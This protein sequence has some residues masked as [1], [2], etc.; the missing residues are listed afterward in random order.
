MKSGIK[1]LYG[2]GLN[3]AD[4]T[5]NKLIAGKRIWCKFYTR[6]RNMLARCYDL[7]YQEN[8]PTYIGCS[9]AKEWHSFM[10]FRGWME[11]QDW[12]GNH[13]DKDLL[14]NGNKVYSPETCVFI[15]HELNNFTLDSS[16]SR[17]LWPV[18]VS[19]HNS[20]GMF[21]AYC[22]NPFSKIKDHI[23]YFSC[24]KEAHLAW[25]KRKHELAC[26][27][28]ALQADQRVATALRVRYL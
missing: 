12:Q 1:L 19:F 14:I 24:P 25:R 17:G 2:V 8:H 20:Y 16:S 13:L 27:L 26:Q 5:V 9:V 11:L 15:S 22:R 6:W 4:Y 28:A 23:G 21:E 3:D 18:G 7:K 10:T